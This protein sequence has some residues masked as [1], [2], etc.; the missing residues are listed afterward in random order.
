[1]RRFVEFAVLK[2]NG[3]EQQQRA[4]VSGVRLPQLE[5]VKL[6]GVAVSILILAMSEFG[7]RL[8]RDHLKHGGTAG[9]SFQHRKRGATLPRS[10]NRYV[11]Q[12]SISVSLSSFDPRLS[13]PD[14]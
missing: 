3:A 1:M 12:S 7:Q 2:V 9:A 6:G 5:T 10:L 11:N 8:R 14:A 4:D 13:V